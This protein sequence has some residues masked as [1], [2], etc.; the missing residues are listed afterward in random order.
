[1]HTCVSL[2]DQAHKACR[3]LHTL[4]LRLYLRFRICEARRDAFA[5]EEELTSAPGRLR[6]H[7][8]YISATIKRLESLRGAQ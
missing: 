2:L 6:A 3:R 7:R 1:M 8:E 5:A 4:P